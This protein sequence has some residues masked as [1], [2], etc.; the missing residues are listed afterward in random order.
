[1][2]AV[3]RRCVNLPPGSFFTLLGSVL[4]SGVRDGS[5]VRNICAKKSSAIRCARGFASGFEGGGARC[6][7]GLVA[8]GLVGL[9]L[10]GVGA[11]AGGF[12]ADGA[13]GGASGVPGAGPFSSLRA[14]RSRSHLPNPLSKGSTTSS[15]IQIRL[16][17]SGA[18]RWA[19][20][21]GIS[22]TGFPRSRR[23]WCRFESDAAGTVR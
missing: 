12:I 3:P 8:V 15:T 18:G 4:R 22:N 2:T 19:K 17:R 23:Y 16:P 13:V 10:V 6:A 7:A 20:M 9:S 1:M 11:I 14:E 21:S 5:S